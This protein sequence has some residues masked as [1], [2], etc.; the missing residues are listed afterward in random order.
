VWLFIGNAWHAAAEFLSVPG[1]AFA[2]PVA[3]EG[4][5]RTGS[6]TKRPSGRCVTV[7]AAEAA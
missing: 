4:R 7:T 3:G 2:R 1:P 5:W 6:W